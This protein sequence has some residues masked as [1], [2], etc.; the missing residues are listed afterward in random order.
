MKHPTSK[1]LPNCSVLVDLAFLQLCNIYKKVRIKLR[2]VEDL[3]PM[4]YSHKMK[5]CFLF[6]TTAGELS[7]ASKISSISPH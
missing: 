2:T 3:F 1:S 6:L 5:P 4:S 7:F